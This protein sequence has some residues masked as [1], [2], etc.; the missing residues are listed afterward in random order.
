MNGNNPENDVYEYESEIADTRD[1][2]FW[3]LQLDGNVFVDGIKVELHDLIEKMDDEVKDNIISSLFRRT[4]EPLA[5][6]EP[7]ARIY[8]CEQIKEI[9][10]SNYSDEVVLSHYVDAHSEF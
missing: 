1:D 6:Q 10:N 3:E 7:M 9:F 2:M 5:D 8:A 4:R